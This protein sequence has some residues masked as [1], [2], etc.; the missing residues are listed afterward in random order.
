LE[1]WIYPISVI[2]SGGVFSI[3]VGESTKSGT[4]KKAEI[5]RRD[6]RFYDRK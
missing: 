1:L 5:Y 2:F 3:S 4:L 6:H